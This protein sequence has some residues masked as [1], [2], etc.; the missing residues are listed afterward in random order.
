[1]DTQNTPIHL[2]LWHKDFW[3]ISLANFF[4][5]ASVYMLLPPLPLFLLSCRADSSFCALLFLLFALGLYLCGPFISRFVQQYRR[6]VVCITAI[7]ITVCMLAYC[8][9]MGVRQSWALM[10]SAYILGSVFG[11]AKMTL[12]STLIV[13]TCESFLRTE[14]NHASAWCARMALAVGPFLGYFILAGWGIRSVAMVSAI[15]AALS[16]WLIATVRF[17]FKAPG[18]IIPHVSLDRFLLPQAAPLFV[19]LMLL[20]MSMGIIVRV[21]HSYFFYVEVLVGLFFALISEK[22]VF[23]NAD[24]KSETFVGC[25]S[26]VAALLLLLLRPEHIGHVLAGVLSGYGIGIIGARF[27]LF[28]I[29]LAKHCERG[30]SQSSYFLSWE[31]G[32]ALGM[33]LGSC[34]G[35]GMALQVSLVGVIVSLAAYNFF[36][37]PW[38]L[39]HKNR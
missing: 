31:T 3:H 36:V 38:Y 4:L 12:S 9:F 32:L 25:I 29:K 22:Y 2:K 16:L 26:L 33:A 27:L 23:A 17:P 34:L 28:F 24:L 1:M 13:D 18:D 21:Q 5:T 8:Y 37:H 11:L 20:T 15:F 14:A 30:T 39:S 10:L 7:G 19:N 35:G 6:N